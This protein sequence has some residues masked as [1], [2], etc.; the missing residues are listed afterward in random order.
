[1][2]NPKVQF[3]LLL[4]LVLFLFSTKESY[5]QINVHSIG[6]DLG[7]IGSADPYSDLEIFPEIFVSGDLFTS[8]FNWK[9]NIGYWDDGVDEPILTD[10]P[11]YSYSSFVLGAELIYLFPITNLERPS[12]V[13]VLSGFSY[14]FVDSEV[15]DNYGNWEDYSKKIT[16]NMFYFNAGMEIHLLL[17]KNITLFLKGVGYYLLNNREALKDNRWRLQLSLGLNYNFKL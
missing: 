9:T 14:H 10:N 4:F 5:S 8:N 1:M 2:I 17:H 7:Y 15:V 13:R 3:A 12:P 16:G 6:F 11:T